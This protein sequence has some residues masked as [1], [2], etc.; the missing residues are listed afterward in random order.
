MVFDEAAYDMLERK[1]K[2]QVAKDNK[3]SQS[4]DTKGIYLPIRKPLGLADYVLVGMEPS[5]KGWARD[6]KEA[7]KKIAGGFRNFHVR[8]DDK[9]SSLSLFRHSI[10]KYLCGEGE[11]YLLTDL[12]KG[13]MTVADAA[14][15]RQER[16]EAWYPLLLQEIELVG[17]PG[18]PVV[19]IGKAVET[20][21]RKKCLEEWT[22]RQLHHVLHY[23]PVASGFRKTEPQRHQDLYREFGSEPFR[24]Q[25]TIEEFGLKDHQKQLV[26]TYKIQFGVVGHSP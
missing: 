22:G 15:N 10:E 2:A 17:K 7:A 4:P 11:S 19:A 13:A 1:F 16:Y 5:L 12:A 18:A 20:F 21:L 23:S 8:P 3:L 6:L 14:D 26:F 9:D 24:C 25:Q